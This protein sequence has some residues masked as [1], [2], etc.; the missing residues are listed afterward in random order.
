MVIV[1]VR[2]GARSTPPLFVPPS[3]FSTTV[4]VALPLRLGTGVKVRVPSGASAGW[5]LNSEVLLFVRIKLS[6]WPLSS[7]GPGVIPVDQAALYGPASA[8][9]DT[10][11]PAVNAGASLTGVTA[12]VTVAGADTAPWSSRAWY[13]KLSAPL[14][15]AA[16]V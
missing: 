15:C 10:F 6:A 8:A 12:I 13:V 11:G 1:R 7:A 2:G 5:L 4:T 3:S 16:G 14:N 9:T